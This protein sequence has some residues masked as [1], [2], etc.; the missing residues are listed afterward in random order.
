[1]SIS[2]YYHYYKCISFIIT[3]I[4][5]YSISGFDHAPD[6]HGR[7]KCPSVQAWEITFRLRLLV[8]SLQKRLKENWVETQYVMFEHGF[9]GVA[10]HNIYIYS[11]MC[12]YYISMR[13]NILLQVPVVI[14][15]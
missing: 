13:R 4:I 11:Y 10:I 3:I 6:Y 5:M 2:K 9:N 12:N 7:V 1:M 15:P 8:G 14:F